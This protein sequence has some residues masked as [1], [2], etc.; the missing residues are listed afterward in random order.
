[1]PA[2]PLVAAGLG[3]VFGLIGAKKQ[4]DASKQIAAQ[5]AATVSP[6]IQAQADNAKWARE[7]AMI[8]LPKARSTLGSSLD[9]WNTILKGDRNQIMS[10]VGPTADQ[11]A[12]QTEAANRNI[13]EF[14]GRG[15]RRT[16]MLGSQ[17]IQTIT[18][19]NRN[20]LSLRAS[21]PD[22]AT[23][24]GQIL[25]QLGLGE[26]NAATTAGGSALSGGLGLANLQTQ[27][28]M[29]SAAASADSYR[30]FGQSLAQILLELQKWKSPGSVSASP[31]PPVIPPSV[32]SGP[33]YTTPPWG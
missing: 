21:A 8:D 11:Q 24:I 27:T 31:H 4:A 12:Q 20:V 6:L 29:Q 14:A 9:F 7:Q 16:L 23:N 5:Q 32:L 25:A 33:I 2:I 13:S 1:M 17:P 15:G 30:T 10:L 3:G 19:M 26:T 28:A 18:D 22:K